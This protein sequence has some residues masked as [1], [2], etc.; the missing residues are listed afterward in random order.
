MA[1]GRK[2]KKFT[3]VI[4]CLTLKEKNCTKFKTILVSY[5]ASRAWMPYFVSDC[6]SWKCKCKS[7]Y[8]FEANS[9]DLA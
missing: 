1:V 2:G 9:V 7:T 3:T 6:V 8:A 4:C 5:M